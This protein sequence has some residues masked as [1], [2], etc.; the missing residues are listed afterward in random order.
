M[1]YNSLSLKMHEENK[2]K[3]EEI[4]ASTPFFFKVSAISVS[5][6]QVQPSFR[7]LPF[8]NKTF[9]INIILSYE[10]SAADY[11]CSGKNCIK[12]GSSE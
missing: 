4:S 10:F 9:I 6:V 7:G 5:A 11:S 1:D 12:S 8:S 2:G 3:V